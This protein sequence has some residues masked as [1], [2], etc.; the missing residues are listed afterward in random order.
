MSRKYERNETQGIQ[1]S[2]VCIALRNELDDMKCIF[3]SDMA[4]V[5][6]TRKWTCSEKEIKEAEFIKYAQTFTEINE[7]GRVEVALPWKPGYPERLPNNCSEAERDL[8]FQKKRLEKSGEFEMYSKE[9]NKL[10]S[11]DFVEPVD[12]ELG[13]SAYYITHHHV[14]RA[15][16]ESTP[17]RIVWNSARKNSHGFCIND[18]L[19]KGPDLLNQIF[20]CLIGFRENPVAFIGDIRKMFNM[21]SLSKKDRR[22]HRFLWWDENGQVIAY[23]WKRLIFG[24][25]PSPDLA[26]T[27]LRFIATMSEKD[28]PRGAKLIMKNAYMDDISGSTLNEEEGKTC[29]SEITNLLKKGK[30]EI[31]C[32][33]S[34][35]AQLEKE[36]NENVTH[37]I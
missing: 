9:M 18:V 31:K 3:T 33:H 17:V 6:P 1:I 21:V 5:T 26:I 37:T 12:I 20:K 24:D 23:Q 19:Y 4:G 36:I 25:S 22:F 14:I 2:N 10:I 16:S 11:S 8:H 35:S 30:F 28:Y 34:N 7:E 27:A 32:W 15:E 29:I 13:E